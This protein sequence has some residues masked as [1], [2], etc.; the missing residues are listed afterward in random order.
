MMLCMARSSATHEPMPVEPKCAIYTRQS[1]NRQ[2][3]FSSCEAQRGICADTAGELGWPVSNESFD[4]SGESSETLDRPAL[5]RLFREIEVGRIDRVL[6]DRIDRLTRRLIDLHKLLA[7]FEQHDVDLKVVTDPHFGENAASRLTSNIVAAAAEFQQDIT[8]ERM[9]DARAALKRIGRR[10]AGRVAFGYATD[11]VTKQL[12]INPSQA[13]LVRQMFDL[14]AAGT[15]PK[16]IAATINEEYRLHSDGNGGR[17]TARQTLKV[18]SNPIYVGQIH[19]RDG[20]LPGSHPAIVAPELFEQVRAQIEGRRS[21]A[22]GRTKSTIDWPLQGKIVCG[23]CGRVMSPSVSG[24]R[25]LQYR[26]YRCRSNA[27]G[28]PPCPDVSV[29]AF[30]AEEFLRSML[31]DG[32]REIDTTNQ[33][34]AQAFT[35]AWREL[36]EQT[37]RAALANVVKSVVFDPGAGTIS[38]TLTDGAGEKLRP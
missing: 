5:Q 35:A 37:Q 22:P 29:P 31:S 15:R 3:L 2:G 32:W 34:Q 20:T 11:P 12:V 24:Y 33:E 27:G 19:H 23:Q 30:E 38:V 17:W 6:V 18:L 1:R 7:F 8:R 36:D 9:A 21:R 28:K 25:N 14:A 16:D 10:V 4:D 26:Y 13:A